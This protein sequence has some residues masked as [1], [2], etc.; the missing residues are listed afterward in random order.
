MDILLERVWPRRKEFDS[1]KRKAM[2]TVSGDLQ[3]QKEMGP[4]IERRRFPSTIIEEINSTFNIPSVESAE[5][6]A[7]HK[8]L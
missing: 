1:F 3:R 6:E 2:E 5:F 4:M 7:L 8:L